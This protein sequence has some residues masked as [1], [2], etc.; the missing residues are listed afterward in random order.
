MHFAFGD[1]GADFHA[2]DEYKIRESADGH[3]R[4]GNSGHGVVVGQGD[5][6]QAPL[7]GRGRDFGRPEGPVGI[8]AVDMEI[9][10]HGEAMI[11]KTRPPYVKMFN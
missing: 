8:P 4:G 11:A 9:R 6:L 5:L 2:G 7:L 1:L 3:Q 10:F